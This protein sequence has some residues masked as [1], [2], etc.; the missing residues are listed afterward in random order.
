MSKTDQAAARL[1]YAVIG[2]GM[3]VLFIGL[4]AGIML[5]FS[6]LD[7]VTLWPLP[8]WE[9]RIPGSSRGWQAAH[10]GG[11]LNGVMIA[12]GALLMHKLDLQGSTARWVGW[13]LIITGWAN[14]IFY[15]AG[16]FAQ[17]RGLSVSTTPFGDGDLAGAIAFLGGGVGMFFTFVAIALLGRRA[18]ELAGQSVKEGD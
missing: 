12:A 10:V 18:F 16:N 5:I 9:V 2:H 6:L 8:A 3:T 7:A 11:I 1:Y 14:T 17:N 13:G 4:I 15:W